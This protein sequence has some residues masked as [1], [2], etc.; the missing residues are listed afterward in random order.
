MCACKVLSCYYQVTN[1]PP[2][3][4]TNLSPILTHRPRPPLRPTREEGGRQRYKTYSKRYTKH[5]TLSTLVYSIV[6]R[7]ASRYRPALFLD[8]NVPVSLKFAHQR[9]THPHSISP[10]ATGHSSMS[11]SSSL[12]SSGNKKGREGRK[13]GEDFMLSS[14][15]RTCVTATPRRVISC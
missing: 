12:G 1:A 6:R 14:E 5:S 13:V 7:S 11:T 9:V 3:S 4:L 10:P 8:H 2:S 15:V